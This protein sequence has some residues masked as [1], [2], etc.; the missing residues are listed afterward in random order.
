MGRVVIF[1]G[2]G[3]IGSPLVQYFLERNLKVTV[4]DVKQNLELPG[5]AEFLSV[6]VTDYSSIDGVLESG[7]RVI[8]AAG[9]SDLDA[10]LDS[11]LDT[12]RVNICGTVNILEEASRVGVKTFLYTSTLYAAGSA[13][14]F[15]GC[16]KRA[17]E[18]YIWEYARKFDMTI[19]IARIGSV[20]GAGSD[21]RNRITRMIQQARQDGIVVYSD[22][23]R[24]SRQYIHIDDLVNCVGHIL[25]VDDSRRLVNVLG[26]PDQR[27]Q[28]LDVAR[29]I[30]K[31]F[32]AQLYLPETGNHDE[33][34]GHYVD[35][36]N[37][38]VEMMFEDF[39]PS[40][41]KSI[42]S[43]LDEIHNE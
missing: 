32:D 8:H 42:M 29:C 7:D 38:G 17:A 14:G 35:Q 11:P 13:G 37:E 2:S 18:S 6:D 41:S 22:H 39:Y 25:E 3:F 23:P 5:E 27:T 28:I 40:Q 21:Q 9:L 12:V 36:P 43:W 19:K 34:R 15:Y 24:A 33:P 4:L 26:P 31:K 10:C 1:G 16:S 20:F 30:A